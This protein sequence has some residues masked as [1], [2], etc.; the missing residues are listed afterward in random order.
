MLILLVVLSV[1]V[2]LVVYKVK[3][4][5]KVNSTVPLSFLVRTAMLGEVEVSFTPALKTPLFEKGAFWDSTKDL[6]IEVRYKSE[7]STIRKS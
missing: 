1:I 7:G 6:V 5:T 3:K 2:I 4:V